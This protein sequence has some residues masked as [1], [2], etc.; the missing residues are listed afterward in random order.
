MTLNTLVKMTGY[1][2]LL[3][4]QLSI[5]SAGQAQDSYRISRPTASDNQ[6][7]RT[8]YSAP[9]QPTFAPQPPGDPSGTSPVD[10]N[11]EPVPS[12]M[13]TANASLNLEDQRNQTYQGAVFEWQ[14]RNLPANLQV[15]DGATMQGA[16][17]AP[18]KGLKSHLGGAFF[19]LGGVVGTMASAYVPGAR[20]TAGITH[21]EPKIEVQAGHCPA[22]SDPAFQVPTAWWSVLSGEENSRN[23]GPQWKLWLQAVQF[24]FQAHA[25]ELRQTPGVSSLH[26]IVNANGSIYNITP[27]TGAER[28][29]QGYPINERSMENLQRMIVSIGSFPPFPAGSKVRAYHLIFNGSAGI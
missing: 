19:K 3:F 7:I 9:L 16:V 20:L 1:S 5:T 14:N 17:N 15:S 10:T 26:V 28:G 12:N 27:Y 11:A 13:L 29:N 21:A 23:L 22:A 24:V 2:F 8:T 18:H 25:T 6:T 4:L